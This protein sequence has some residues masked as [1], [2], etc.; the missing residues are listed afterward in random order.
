VAFDLAAV[1]QQL[2]ANGD[3]ASFEVPTRF[4]EIGSPAGLAATRAHIAQR[5]TTT[6]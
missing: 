3:L 1:Y 2:L 4:Y 5:E 6:R